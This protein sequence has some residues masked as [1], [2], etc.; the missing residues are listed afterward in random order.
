[1]PSQGTKTQSS[2]AGPAQS[3][4][5]QSQNTWTGF[6]GE[7]EGV[8]PLTSHARSA[9]LTPSLL[10]AL[11]QTRLELAIFGLERRAVFN[12]VPSSHMRWH[13]ED[14]RSHPL[15]SQ[16]EARLIRGH[17][18]YLSE[19]L[20]IAIQ[21]LPPERH[22]KHGGLVERFPSNGALITTRAI[23]R[24]EMHRSWFKWRGP[25]PA[26]FQRV[27]VLGS[28]VFAHRY[29]HGGK[30]VTRFWAWQRKGGVIRWTEVCSPLPPRYLAA[31]K[32]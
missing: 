4:L 5:D 10:E 11:W 22:I 18:R 2:S 32:Q 1:M 24:L 23:Q 17:A 29:S 7:S 9:V 30:R 15:R 28:A 12:Y 20:G 14:G 6:A 8:D 3:A 27:P 13:R 25:L 16:L 31:G 21:P 26:K 19:V